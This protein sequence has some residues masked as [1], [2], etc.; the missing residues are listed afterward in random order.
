MIQRIERRLC[1]LCKMEIQEDPLSMCGCFKTVQVYTKVRF[2]LP[3]G[4]MEKAQNYD[5]CTNCEEKLIDWIEQ[6]TVQLDS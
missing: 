4:E 3:R 6:N 1:D 5:L 2:W